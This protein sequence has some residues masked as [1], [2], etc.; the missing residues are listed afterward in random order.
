M[1]RQ[2]I[3]E[4]SAAYALHALD[5]EEER[6]YEDHLAHCVECREEVA[7]F[8][9]VSGAMAH[10]VEAPPP[11]PAL[12]QRI[13]DRARGERTTVVPLRRRWIFPAAAATA[14]AA[15]V[16]AVGLG[17]WAATLS[18]RLEDER[19]ANARAAQIVQLAGAR[20][21]LVVT[22]SGE[23][24]LLVKGLRPAPEGKT[25]EVWVIQGDMPRRAGIFAGGERTAFVLTRPVPR[26]AVV[27]VTLEV[28]GGV[29][30]PT[31]TPLFTAKSA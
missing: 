18:S 15:S 22:P 2:G 16:A 27:A 1:E 24:T 8:Q 23:A 17:I 9:E 6:A 13:L 20:G 10:G 29:D 25:Y 28:A 11:P 5:G 4:L 3:H 26:G 30:Q 14:V 31:G 12:K 21:S 7:S 19:A